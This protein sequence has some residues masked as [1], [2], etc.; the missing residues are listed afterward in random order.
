[1]TSPLRVY[2]AKI[3]KNKKGDGNPDKLHTRDFVLVDVN[4]II[5]DTKNN[6]YYNHRKSQLDKVLTPT[7]RKVVDKQIT[8]KD[9]VTSDRLETL[10][11]NKP[12]LVRT[13]KTNKPQDRQELINKKNNTNNTIKE[14]FPS[15]PNRREGKNF[16]NFGGKF[17]G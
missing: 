16:I 9:P 6:E 1:M 12:E 11:Q 4:T 3:S 8:K 2:Y 7:P 10:F 14:L 13:I 5:V 17:K 15:K